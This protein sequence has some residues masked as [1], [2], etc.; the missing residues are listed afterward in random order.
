MRL[1]EYY[2]ADETFVPS[3]LRDHGCEI[4][5]GLG[6]LQAVLTTHRHDKAV[7][8]GT[9]L[10]RIYDTI[11]EKGTLDH[12]MMYNHITKRDGWNGG[13]S[14]GWGYNY[15]GYLCYD[16]AMGSNVYTD[17]MKATLVNMM[18]P[19]YKNYPWEG[20]SIDGY[21]DSIEGAIY[22][23]NRLPVEE[24]FEWVDR[25]TR[26]NVVDHPSRLQRGELWGT[27]KLQAN[28]V[29]TTIMH[30]LMH[31]RGIVARPWQQGLQLGAAQADDGVVIVVSSEKDYEGLLEFDI[32]RHRL[33]MGFAKD[34]PRMNTL[35][36]WF[37]VEP[38][39][40]YTV[41]FAGSETAGAFTGR[42]L[43]NGLAVQLKAGETLSLAVSPK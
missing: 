29:R 20:E 26:N 9:H 5:G 31:T 14:D 6:L 27:M 32:P 33:Y 11:L 12:G 30:A 35:P 15:V 41:Q 18:A 25:E 39:A 22:M 19:K 10:K 16:M 1:A 4:V 28:G 24:G 38:E 8:Y 17:H 37:V 23:L 34:W 42:Q 3:R 40:E 36:E 13:V 2:F 7:E 43:H 21:A